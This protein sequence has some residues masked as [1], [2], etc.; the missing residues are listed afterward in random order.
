[1]AN[2]GQLCASLLRMVLCLTLLQTVAPNI[3]AFDCA[4]QMSNVTKI[5]IIE[6]SPCN[7]DI[8]KTV[9]TSENIFLVQTVS[10]YP[11][12]V[13]QCKVT[14]E[15]IIMHCGVISDSIVSGGLL[16]YIDE[17]SQ[18]ECS[19]MHKFRSTKFRGTHDMNDL[20]L[21]GTKSFTAILA[22]SVNSDGKC[23]SGTYSDKMGTWE[24]VYVLANVKISLHNSIRP[25]SN[26]DQTVLLSSGFRCRLSDNSCLDPDNGMTFWRDVITDDC[27]QRNFE[28]LY[29]GPANKSVILMNGQPSIMYTSGSSNSFSMMIT[30]QT[31]VCGH[32]ALQSEHPKLKIIVNNGVNLK[33]RKTKDIFNLDMFTY[34]NSKFAYVERHIQTQ[35]TN[36]HRAHIENQCRI[37]KSLLNT[38]LSIAQSFPSEFAYLRMGKQG[39]TALPAGEVMY[40][41]KCQPVSV[42]RSPKSECYLEFPVEYKNRTFFMAPRT[43]L[44][45]E[46]GTQ[47]PCSEVVPVTYQISGQWFSFSPTAHSV[48]EP[49]QLMPKSDSEWEYTQPANLMTSGIY[50]EGEIENLRKTLMF[51]S[52]KGAALNSIASLMNGESINRNDFN[53]NDFTDKTVLANV[54]DNY[55]SKASG[56]FGWLGQSFSVCIGL[57]FSAKILKFLLDTIIHGWALYNKYGFDMRMTAMFWDALT[58]HFLSER[59]KN[60]NHASSESGV[61]ELSE[62]SLRLYPQMPSCPEIVVS[63]TKL[64][65]QNF[66]SRAKF[67][68]CVKDDS[69]YIKMLNGLKIKEEGYVSEIPCTDI[70]G[71]EICCCYNTKYIP[72]YTETRNQ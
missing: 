16:E 60:N 5:N 57:W 47:V 39:Y 49:E 46:K 12:H 30:S 28:L 65:C 54:L 4:H 40:L 67:S 1:M 36:L 52:E 68:V 23:K 37:E 13:Y 9:T 72:I 71:V 19:D 62:H 25:V 48:K 31:T 27:E 58:T 32:N 64:L 43:H 42:K 21:N 70:T 69:S 55:F 44:L 29:E 38:Q 26:N 8:T 7:V 6:P 35:I 45:Q 18:S 50:S 17:T 63:H 15:R 22:G 53:Y 33:F 3:I 20:T 61:K 51:P 2:S 14:V 10:D 41:V 24:D 56:I 59:T 34:F 66:V 11:L